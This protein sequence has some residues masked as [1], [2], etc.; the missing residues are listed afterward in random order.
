MVLKEPDVQKIIA[1]Y[2]ELSQQ[3]L[4]IVSFICSILRL[5]YFRLLIN[6]SNRAAE[7]TIGLLVLI[8]IVINLCGIST[9]FKFLFSNSKTKQIGITGT[10]ISTILLIMILSLYS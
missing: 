2:T 7:S 6:F 3:N 10:I 5:I 1:E 9:G 8:Q 4:G